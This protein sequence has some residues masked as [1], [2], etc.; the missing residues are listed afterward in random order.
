[1]IHFFVISL[2][3]TRSDIFKPLLIIKIPTYSF[4]NSFFELQ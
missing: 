2:I 4:L 3:I 1:M